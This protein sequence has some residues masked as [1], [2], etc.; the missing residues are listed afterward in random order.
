MT[1]DSL[2]YNFKTSA[3]YLGWKEQLYQDGILERRILFCFWSRDAWK[4]IIQ[5]TGLKIT[6]YIQLYETVNTLAEDNFMLAI[7]YVRKQSSFPEEKAEE[8]AHEMLVWWSAE[9]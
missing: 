2:D 4:N 8:V 1:A 3:K 6:L 7:W 9:V 5:L